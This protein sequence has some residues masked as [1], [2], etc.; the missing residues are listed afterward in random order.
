MIGDARTPDEA[1]RERKLRELTD[2]GEII[3]AADYKKRSRRAFLT[4]AGAGAVG[5]AGFKALQSSGSRDGDNIPSLLRNG[6]EFNQSVWQTLERDGA[7]AR[8]FST[9]DREEIRIN[10]R[11][12]LQDSGDELIQVSE[13]EA[14][15]WEIA[16]TDV[17]GSALD[18]IPLSVIKSDFEVQNIVWEHKCVEGW[19]NIVHWTGVRVSDVLERY[20]PDQLNNA[21][22]GV[23]RTP[24]STDE[25]EQERE[26]SAAIDQY[27][28]NHSQSLFAWQ[29]NGEELTAGHGSPIRL[30]TPLKYGIKQIK[31]VGIIDFANERPT[32]YWT[33][34]GYD[35]HAGF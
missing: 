4:F 26:Y 14:A 1:V 30:V 11:H 22:W 27:T 7:T 16:M 19:A 8:T 25:G 28:L 32:D 12:G 34:R 6:L 23:M 24:A 31:R 21:D 33:T 35:L 15:S 17:D 29:L 3:S 18:P 13:E 9:S 5:F 2:N 10:G 20:A